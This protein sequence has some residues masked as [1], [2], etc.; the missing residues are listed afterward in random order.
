[1]PANGQV[2]KLT[3]LGFCL[4]QVIFTEVT[5]TE[6]I[7]FQDRLGRLGFGDRYQGDLLRIPFTGL[8]ATGYELPNLC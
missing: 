1:M 3:D 5:L 6:L 4:L 7:G 2:I 8:S